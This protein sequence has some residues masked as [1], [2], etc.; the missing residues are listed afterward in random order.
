MVQH[1]NG[2]NGKG[3][4]DKLK[5]K[6]GMDNWTAQTKTA[7]APTNGKTKSKSA[8][9][10]WQAPTSTAP[11]PAKGTTKGKSATDDWQSPK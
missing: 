2:G 4:D 8:S 10:D 7:P 3:G 5:S 1:P 11:Q 6:S 9:D